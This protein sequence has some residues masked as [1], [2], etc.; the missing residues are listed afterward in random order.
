MPAPGLPVNHYRRETQLL[1]NA[2]VNELLECIH[3]DWKPTDNHKMISRTFR[4]KN[5]YPT[6]T[7]INPLTWKIHDQ[8]HHPILNVDYNHS[9]LHYSTHSFG[10]LS[11]NDF[12]CA[13]RI[14]LL[15]LNNPAVQ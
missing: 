5:Y 3:S 15:S 11:E 4:F 9:N 7:F 2:W 6:S 14:D 13:A 1:D 8:D 10:G 12:I